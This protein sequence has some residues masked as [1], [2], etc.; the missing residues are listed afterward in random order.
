VVE[1]TRVKSADLVVVG[2]HGPRGSRLWS[3][4]VLATQ[5]ARAVASP[6][7]TVSD[8]AVAD[9]NV[10]ASFK[11]IVCG[12]DFSPASLRALD[13]GLGMA[14]RSGGR[15]TLLHVLEGFPYESGHS[16][17][18]TF[19]LIGED[20]GRVDK[21]KRK[22]RALVLP[23]ALNWSEVETEVVSGVP[24]DAIVATA[25]ARMADLV[26]IGRPSPTLDRIVMASTVSGVLRRARCPVLAVPGASEA[27][28]VSS[29]ADDGDRSDDEAMAPWTLRATHRFGASEIKAL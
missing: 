7:L 5:I 2:Q 28:D 16:G 24:H 23:D 19:Q 18:R 25:T 26:V 20:L 1:Y 8:E 11:N 3:S 21:V 12:I 10:T 14:Q 13:E 29:K 27:T 15:I 4:G 17:A 9:K 6:T 22:L